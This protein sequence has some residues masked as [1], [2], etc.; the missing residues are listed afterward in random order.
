MTQ[1]TKEAGIGHEA[2]YKALH[3]NSVPR[4]DTIHHVVNALVPK[5]TVQYA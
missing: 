1:I 5:F 2:L 4:F 3:P